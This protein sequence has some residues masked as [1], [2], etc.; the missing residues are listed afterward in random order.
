MRMLKEWGF[1]IS[2][3]PEIDNC[4]RSMRRF[5][6]FIDS[7]ARKID[8]REPLGITGVMYNSC[9]VAD[10][11]IIYPVRI[12]RLERV[13]GIRGPISSMRMMNWQLEKIKLT[14][15]VYTEKGIYYIRLCDFSGVTKSIF[16][17]LLEG[18]KSL[19]ELRNEPLRSAS[20]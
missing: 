15:R 8:F 3:M 4:M 2:L 17:D 10:G 16:D 11:T 19:S 7:G 6:N 20:I 18:A 12:R 13:G 1:V 9:Y 14:Y 5:L